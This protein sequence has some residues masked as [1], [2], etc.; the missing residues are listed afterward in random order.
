MLTGLPPQV[1]HGDVADARSVFAWL[2]P[3]R[4]GLFSDGIAGIFGRAVSA[5]AG[6]YFGSAAGSSAGFSGGG[7]SNTTVVA[8]VDS[9]SRQQ[10]TCCG[11]TGCPYI[12][13]VTKIQSVRS[14]GSRLLPGQAPLSQL[15]CN[16]VVWSTPIQ[17]SLH[18]GFTHFLHQRQQLLVGVAGPRLARFL[19]DDVAL[20][21]KLKSDDTD[22]VLQEPH[23]PP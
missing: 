8:C 22:D 12:S 6:F 9:Q 2:P 4:Y 10:Y 14:A 3:Y 21:V 20:L 13:L 19:T 23:H 17:V 5:M 16:V 18:E 1:V 7:A 11:C 15:I